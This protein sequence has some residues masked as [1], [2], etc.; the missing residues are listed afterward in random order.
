[1]S[2]MSLINN[3]YVNNINLIK[4]EKR[5]FLFDFMVTQREIYML[6]H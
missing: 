5:A 2:I 3:V 6:A 1:M 4:E